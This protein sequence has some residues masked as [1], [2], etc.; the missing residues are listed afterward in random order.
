MFSAVLPENKWNKVHLIVKDFHDLVFIKTKKKLELLN[1]WMIATTV[2]TH[3]LRFS[4]HNQLS[5]R[6]KKENGCVASKWN[7]WKVELVDWAENYLF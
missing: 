7:F 5:I 6:L 2:T 4:E 3:L 1:E